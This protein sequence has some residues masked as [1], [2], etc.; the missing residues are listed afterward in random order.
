M[1]ARVMTIHDCEKPQVPF[2]EITHIGTKRNWYGRKVPIT[3]IERKYKYDYVLWTCGE[4]KTI[5]RWRVGM[6]DAHWRAASRKEIWKDI[7]L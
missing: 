7:E 4:C 5:W 6:V 2:E 3:W 1:L